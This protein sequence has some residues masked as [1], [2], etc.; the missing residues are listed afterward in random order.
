M[1]HDGIVD[2]LRDRCKG[3]IENIMQAPDRQSVASASLAI[4]TQM[5]PVAR[6]ILQAKIALEAR[7]LM[8]ADVIPCCQEAGVSLVHP[9]TVSPETL[10]GEITIPVRTFQCRGCGATF[11]P[12]DTVLGVPETGDFTDDVRYLYAPLAAELPHRVANPAGRRPSSTVQPRTSGP[13]KPSVRAARL[14]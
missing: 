8:R 1:D 10:F 2:H 3:F 11:R 4:L 5:R 14:R 12:D 6:D 7:Q 9:R 13:G